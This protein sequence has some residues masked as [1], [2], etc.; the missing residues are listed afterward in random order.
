[1]AL[2]AA[3]LAGQYAYTQYNQ[4]VSTAP[5]SVAAVPIAPYTLVTPDMLQVR[6]LPRPL[7]A[8]PIYTAPDELIGKM[9]TQALMPGQII[10]HH[11]AVAPQAFRLASPDLEVVSL[12][13][14]VEQAVGGAIRS[15]S[16]VNLYR[17]VTDQS[18]VQGGL[19]HARNALASTEASIT[20]TQFSEV[21]LLAE[22]APVVDVREKSGGPATQDTSPTGTAAGNKPQAQSSS[23]Q[24]V[25]IQ[26]VTLAVR[27]DV[28]Q[29]I[30][31]LMGE[32]GAAVKFWL[33]LA[34]VAPAEPVEPVNQD[35]ETP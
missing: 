1:V 31:R 35:Q 25:P 27:H 3:V 2:A 17:M 11:Q 18:L 28:A 34:P 16:R 33:T 21:T 24:R 9:T 4:I 14:S 7:A 26:I 30:V 8:E 22:N 10:Y 29:D 13:V 19:S 32:T 6:N 5:V 12:P 23:S 15:G 20:S